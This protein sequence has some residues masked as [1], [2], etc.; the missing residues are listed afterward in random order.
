MNKYIKP[1]S[2]GLIVRFPRPPFVILPEAGATINW[3]GNDGRYWR[4]RVRSGDVVL[5]K[6][7]IQKTVKPNTK[8]GNK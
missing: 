3:N 1:A 5:S 6:P 8:K 7:P 4:R 2:A